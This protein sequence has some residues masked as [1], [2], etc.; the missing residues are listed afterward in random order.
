MDKP[1]WLDEAVK[2]HYDDRLQNSEIV[3]T[4]HPRSTTY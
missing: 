2:M 4:F 1:I 3:Q